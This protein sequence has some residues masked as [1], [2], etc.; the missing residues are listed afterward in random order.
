MKRSEFFLRPVAAAVAIAMT[1]GCASVKQN[2]EKITRTETTAIALRDAAVN[3][4][5]SGSA[6]VGFTAGRFSTLPPMKQ[7]LRICV[8]TVASTP[9]SMK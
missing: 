2:D 4:T 1:V 8:I 7:R 5:A 6:P 9:S 3:N